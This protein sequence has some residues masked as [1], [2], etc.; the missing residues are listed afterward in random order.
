MR[1]LQLGSGKRGRQLACYR[2][3][4][5]GLLQ[6]P[7][8]LEPLASLESWEEAGLLQGQELCS[9]HLESLESWEE[10]GLLQGQELCSAQLEPLQAQ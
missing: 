3:L 7:L 2:A 10:A 8:E 5:A 4:L 6:G 1:G 9:A